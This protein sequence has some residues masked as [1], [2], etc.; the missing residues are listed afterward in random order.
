M[1]G[2][3]NHHGPESCANLPR[4][5]REAFDRGTHRPGIEPRKGVLTGS[6]TTFP[7]WEGNTLSSVNRKRESGS[8]GSQTLRM[9]GILFDRIW[10][11]SNGIVHRHDRPGKGR[12]PKPG[13]YAIEKSDTAV[14][15]KKGSNHLGVK[16]AFSVYGRAWREGL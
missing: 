7:D 12:T 15:P 6:P 1:E 13:M 11:I 8:S 5:G 16:A 9:C 4:G 10:E 14:V 2:I 3:A